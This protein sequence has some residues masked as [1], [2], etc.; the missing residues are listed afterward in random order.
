MLD[1]GH[2]AAGRAVAVQTARLFLCMQVDPGLRRFLACGA[3]HLGDGE[4]SAYSVYHQ[5][6]EQKGS[7]WA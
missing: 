4:H 1:A 3:E 5:E 2:A 6:N 7:E